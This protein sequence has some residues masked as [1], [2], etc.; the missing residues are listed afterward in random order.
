MEWNDDEDKCSSEEGC[1]SLFQKYAVCT[2]SE[3]YRIVTLKKDFGFMLSTSLYIFSF[4]FN[5]K[6]FNYSF[7]LWEIIIGAI[8]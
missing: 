1:G 6:K 5:R 2:E 8:Y 4:L 7:K 3:K